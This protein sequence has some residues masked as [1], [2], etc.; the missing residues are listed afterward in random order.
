MVTYLA[1]GIPQKA[2]FTGGIVPSG[3]LR[4]E[5]CEK[6]DEKILPEVNFKSI[7]EISEILR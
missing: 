5:G 6:W 7:F 1:L 2:P 3:E 4:G